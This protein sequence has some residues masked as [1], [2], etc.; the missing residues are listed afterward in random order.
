MP[1]RIWL[2]TQWE[3]R[4]AESDCKMFNKLSKS[5]VAS[6]PEKAESKRKNKK[7]TQQPKEPKPTGTIPDS[8]PVSER[9]KTPDVA[10]ESQAMTKSVQSLTIDTKSK[11]KKK[12][13]IKRKSGAADTQEHVKEH[14][15]LPSQTEAAPE[16]QTDIVCRDVRAE[17]EHETSVEQSTAPASLSPSTSPVLS[18]PQPT[19]PFGTARTHFSPPVSLPSSTPCSFITAAAADNSN[20]AGEVEDATTE[21]AEPG[22]DTSL[23]LT[24][25]EK[26]VEGECV[27]PVLDSQGY[28]SGKFNHIILVS[29]KSA[30][31]E[32]RNQTPKR[33]STTAGKC[34]RLKLHTLSLAMRSD[35]VSL[36]PFTSL[37]PLH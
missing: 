31:N 22:E 30:A 12:K 8:V 25:L 5:V 26:E 15:E 14:N 7:K 24:P 6:T 36:L 4:N 16:V 19:S 28:L 35:W 3:T 37:S 1:A 21:Q 32:V 23:C 34:W 18:S 13:K 2:R 20:D 17:R 10:E 9:P 33:T 27:W 29:S 11:S